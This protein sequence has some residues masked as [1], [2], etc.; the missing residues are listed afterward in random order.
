M[1]YFLF[2][3]ESRVSK[4]A[5]SADDVEYKSLLI[6]KTEGADPVLSKGADND[7]LL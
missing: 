3:S 2:F 7:L 1:F 4:S 6:T 5:S